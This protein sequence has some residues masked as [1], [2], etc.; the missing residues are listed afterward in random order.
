MVK[1]LISLVLVSAA[2]VAAAAQ[3]TLE[4]CRTL[5]A[6][7]YPLIHRYGLL[8]GMHKIDLSDINKSWLPQIGVYGQATIQNVVPALPE[9]L[10]EMLQE[11]GFEYPGLS[12]AQYKAGI[13]LSQTVWDGGAS[14]AR[15]GVERALDEERRSSLEVQMY[16]INERVDNLYFSILLIEEQ[17]YQTEL[18]QR[19]LESNLAKLRSMKK[20]GTA[21]QSDID[22]LEAQYLTVGQQL[23]QAKSGAALCRRLLGIYTG[24]DLT[25]CTLTRPVAAVPASTV[26]ERPELRYYE[27]RLRSNEM[28]LGNIKASLMPKIGLFAQAYYGYPGFDYFKSMRTRDLSFNVLAGVKVSWNIGS[29]YTRGNSERRLRLASEEVRNERDVFLFNTDLQTQSQTAAISE[30]EE[31]MREDARIVE[32]RAAVRRAAESQLENGVIDATALLTKIT[33]E[34]LARLNASYH[35]IQF[36]QNIYKLKNTLNR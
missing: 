24:R 23:I 22:M 2:C 9:M 29:F 10:S 34:N 5:A 30:F 28:Q 7:N 25:G 3:M 16:A 6:G 13:D 27:N 4:E 1:R 20:N 17:I 14:K 36:L 15:R 11:K 32:L 31:L 33:D 26:S 18:T 19:L 35:E 8:E 21:M 12:K